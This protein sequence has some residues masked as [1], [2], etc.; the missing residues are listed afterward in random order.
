VAKSAKEL[1]QMLE[2]CSAYLA[3]HDAASAD[4]ADPTRVATMRMAIVYALSEL[5]RIE[6]SLVAASTLA[7][8]CADHEPAELDPKYLIYAL[9]SKATALARL[10]RIDEAA[11]IYAEI[12]VRYNESGDPAVRTTAALAMGARSRLLMRDP[13]A[14]AQGIAV[15][16][17]LVEMLLNEPDDDALEIAEIAVQHMLMLLSYDGGSLGAI[18]VL[19]TQGLLANVATAWRTVARHL[20]EPIATPLARVSARGNLG[21]V[22]QFVDIT[23]RTEQARRVGQAVVSRVASLDD[24]RAARLSAKA[25]MLGVVFSWILGDIVGGMRRLEALNNR[26]DPAVAAVYDQMLD[27]LDLSTQ[28]GQIRATMLLNQ[29]AEALIGDDPGL[30]RLAYQDSVAGRLP[31]ARSW[32]V[33]GAVAFFTPRGK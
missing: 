27:D 15:S 31:A 2:N 25:E 9:N 1:T 24:P 20:P 12:I 13:D 16:E 32:P 11:E 23:A 19:A 30:A 5:E 8:Y 3:K 22:P 21:Q 26:H 10:K 4:P 28:L 6:E 33:R 18:T 7:A 29:R 17:E 14:F